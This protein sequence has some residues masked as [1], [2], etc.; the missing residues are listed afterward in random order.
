MD[1][2]FTAP[3][4]LFL[5]APY[6][7]EGSWGLGGKDPRLDTNSL[8]ER[9]PYF[10]VLNGV[11]FHRVEHRRYFAGGAARKVSVAFQDKWCTV[12]IVYSGEWG[13]QILPV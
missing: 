11:P 13:L 8:D 1:D 2:L 9:I 3:T 7:H 4:F 6:T 12:Y 10:Y 5:S